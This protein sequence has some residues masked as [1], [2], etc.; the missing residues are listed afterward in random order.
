MLNWLILG[1]VVFIIA[2]LLNATFFKLQPASGLATWS[3]TVVIFLSSL[4][5]LAVLNIITFQQISSDLGI[6]VEPKNPFNVWGAATFA[7]FFFTMLKRQKK[8][9]VPPSK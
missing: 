1:V 6:R 2:K 5:A 3:L 9:T 7:W 4:A 8:N